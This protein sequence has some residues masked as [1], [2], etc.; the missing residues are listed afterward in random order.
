MKSDFQVPV[1]VISISSSDPRIQPS[2]KKEIID[3][4]TIQSII[5]ISFNPGLSKQSSP[6]SATSSM[7]HE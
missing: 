4:G 5:D 2:I 1:N 6:S 3:P 7:K